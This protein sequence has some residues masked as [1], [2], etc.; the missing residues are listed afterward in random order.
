MLFLYISPRATELNFCDTKKKLTKM[1]REG[2]NFS[3]SP[4]KSCSYFF[5]ISLIYPI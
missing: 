1:E 3:G 4:E 5:L 2:T